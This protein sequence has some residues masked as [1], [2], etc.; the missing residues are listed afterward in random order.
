[1]ID[2]AERL[3]TVGAEGTMRRWT[4]EGDNF[5]EHGE[6]VDLRRG[7]FAAASGTIAEVPIVVVA[8]ADRTVTVWNLTTGLR[9]DDEMLPLRTGDLTALA[10]TNIGGV[11]HVLIALRDGTVRLWNL[12]TLSEASVLNGHRGAVVDLACRTIDGV[13]TA[14]TVG[15]DRQAVVWDLAL[16]CELERLAL[17][18]MGQCARWTREGHLVLGFGRDIAVFDGGDLFYGM[19]DDL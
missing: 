13:A 10:C 9:H 3:V 4:P 18:D 11:A 5:A 12:L 15:E 2:G 16:G 7:A 17:P 19:D 6:S 8:G 14:V 1:V